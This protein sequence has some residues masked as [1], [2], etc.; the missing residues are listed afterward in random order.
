MA[1]ITLTDE[2]ISS[3][4]S[5]KKTVINPGAKWKEQ[6]GSKQKNYSLESD[7]GHRFTLYIRQNVR[8]PHGFSCG[9][10]LEHPIAGPVTLTRYNGSDHEHRNPLDGLKLEPACHIHMATERYMQA[11]RKPEHH[12]EC[13]DRY[14]DLDGA[15]R[16]IV[17]D[18]NIYGIR[19]AAIK[20]EPETNDNQPDMFS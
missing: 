16:S 19:L 13:T 20:A 15:L 6:R 5:A 7:D 3:L 10:S 8:L 4:L 18:C 11:G 17:E 1:E 12:A 2:Q 9:L 14:T